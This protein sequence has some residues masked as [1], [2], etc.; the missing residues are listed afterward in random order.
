MGK[1]QMAVVTIHH[2]CARFPLHRE[3]SCAHTGGG[4]VLLTPLL[5]LESNPRPGHVQR[6]LPDGAPLGK[7]SLGSQLTVSPIYHFQTAVKRK[8]Q[9]QIQ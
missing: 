4:A 7:P 3:V 9:I 8:I 5:T 1:C 6:E 2:W